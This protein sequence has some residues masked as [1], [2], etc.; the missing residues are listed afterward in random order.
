MYTEPMKLRLWALALLFLLP[1]VGVSAS[2]T[3]TYTCL[4]LSTTGSATC[5]GS[6]MNGVF[7]NGNDQFIYDAAPALNLTVGTW[8]VTLVT[9]LTNGQISSSA[10]GNTPVT[11]S[12]SVNDQAITVAVAGGGIAVRNNTGG[13]KSAGTLTYLCVSDT[14]GVCTFVPPTPTS[15][16]LFSVSTSTCTT[17]S[18]VTTCVTIA[19]IEVTHID[20]LVMNLWILFMLSLIVIGM[21]YTSFKH[22]KGNPQ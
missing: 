2:T 1:A 22:K 21:F 19:P 11:I 9:T 5:S 16:P 13:A 6:T 15:S 10:G 18:G 14:T 20:W 17:T 7:T 12:G 8:Y 4:D 3:H